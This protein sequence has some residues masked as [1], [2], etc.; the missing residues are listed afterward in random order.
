LL[1]IGGGVA[2]GGAVNWL[3]ARATFPRTG[4]V[5][6]ERRGRSQV[7]RMLA[8]AFI[9]AV[10]AGSIVVVNRYGASLTVLFGLVFM[11]A[12]AF[13]GYRFGLRRYVLLGIGAIVLGLAI[14]PLSLGMEQ[15]SAV[16]FAVFGLAMLLLGF[17]TWRQYDRVAPPFPEA[18][19]GSRP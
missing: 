13:L 5:D 6:Y 11:G 1:L 16:F 15:A 12:F 18:S 7:V 8:V 2:V 17:F 14:V 10:A 9:A 19:N 3:K 4:Y